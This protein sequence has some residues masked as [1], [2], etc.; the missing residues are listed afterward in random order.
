M[1][2]VDEIR[3]AAAKLLSLVERTSEAPWST[4]WNAQQYEVKSPSDLDPIAEW[5]YGIATWEPEA[6]AH[7]AECDTANADWIATMHPGVGALLAKWLSTEAE[8]HADDVAA[9]EGDGA[10]VNCENF[11][12][13]LAIARAINGGTP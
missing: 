3:A 6:S 10:G 12:M 13:A 11:P 8:L 4:T 1:S 9:V 5:T 7:R 2:P